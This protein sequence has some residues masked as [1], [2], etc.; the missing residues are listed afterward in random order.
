MSCLVRI[1]ELL[2]DQHGSLSPED[3]CYYLFEYTAHKR[4]NYSRG[5]RLIINCKKPM[6][7]RGKPEWGYKQ[8]AIREIARELGPCLPAVV[9]FARAT[10][11]PVPPSKIRAHPAYDDRVLQILQ[12]ACPQGSDIRE[13][14]ACREDREA[15][16]ESDHNRPSVAEI[17]ANY[18]LNPSVDAVVREKV[19]IF[20]DMITAGSHYKAC[21]NFIESRFPGRTITGVFAA[22]RAIPG[23]PPVEDFP[24]V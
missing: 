7:R 18:Y 8:N 6:D 9:D 12:N 24:D 17:Q 16:H 15:A 4:T 14:L 10:V 11:I 21:R 23:M 5:N 20:D 2:L 13:L 1:D 22:R 19:I 3:E